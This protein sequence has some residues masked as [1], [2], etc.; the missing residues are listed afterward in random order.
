MLPDEHDREIR[1]RKQRTD[2]EKYFIVNK[3]IKL[4]KQLPTEG[5]ATFFFLSHIF[6]K[7]VRKVIISEVKWREGI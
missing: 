7:R 3:T 2:V 5:L 6:I 4:W 1:T